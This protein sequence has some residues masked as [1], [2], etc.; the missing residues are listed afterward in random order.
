LGIQKAVIPYGKNQIS[1]GLRLIEKQSTIKLTKNISDS[2]WIHEPHNGINR[3]LIFGQLKHH[4]C[5]L[6]IQ[7]T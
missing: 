1:P 4:G 7:G 3:Y 6:N 5:T 2:F